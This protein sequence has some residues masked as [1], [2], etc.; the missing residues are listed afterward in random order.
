MNSIINFQPLPESLIK[1]VELS[2]TTSELIL[3]LA[4]DLERRRENIKRSRRLKQQ[5]VAEHLDI[6]LSTFRKYEKEKFASMPLDKFIKMLELYEESGI[7]TGF[8][9]L[10]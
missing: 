7:D 6:G 2:K 9:N 5:E 1:S 4:Q 8:S 3:E 10:I